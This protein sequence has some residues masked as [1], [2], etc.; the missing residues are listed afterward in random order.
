MMMIFAPVI[1]SSDIEKHIITFIVKHH[2][3]SILA[4]NE[5]DRC[6][7]LSSN[8]FASQIAYGQTT[9]GENQFCIISYMSAEV[10][11]IRLCIESGLMW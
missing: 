8:W 2:E 1:G 5:V 6:C 4:P 7:S 9:G 11:K 10:E 3:A